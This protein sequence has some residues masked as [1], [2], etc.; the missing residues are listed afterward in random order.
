MIVCA[1]ENTEQNVS[2]IS[3][4]VRRNIRQVDDSL[5]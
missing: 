5:Y 1:S 2:S 4:N 3:M